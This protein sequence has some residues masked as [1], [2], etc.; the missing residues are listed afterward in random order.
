MP[1]LPLR[2]VR[3]VDKS[4][5]STPDAESKLEPFDSFPEATHYVSKLHIYKNL[6]RYL[7]STFAGRTVT[8]PSSRKAWTLFYACLLAM[9]NINL[10]ASLILAQEMRVRLLEISILLDLSSIPELL[11]SLRQDDTGLAM[12][13]VNVLSNTK[14]KVLSLKDQEASK[15]LNLMQ[16]ILDK[17]L[18]PD[19]QHSRKA[20]RFFVKLSETSDILPHTVSIEGVTLGN[21]HPVSRGGFADIYYGEYGNRAVA[22]KRLIIRRDQDSPKIQRVFRREALVWQQLRHP[23]ILPFLGVTVVDKFPSSMCMVSP[24]M[25]NGTIREL[26]RVNG[27]LNINIPRRI[28]EIG[29]G[30]AYLHSEGIIHGDLR[31]ANILV[32]DSWHA[33]LADFGLTVFNDATSAHTPSRHGSARWMAPELFVPEEFGMPFQRTKATDAYAFACVC[34]EI[35]AGHDPFF[36]VPVDPAVMLRV[37]QGLRPARPTSDPQG[38]S[39]DMPDSTWAL[40]QRCWTH[41]P[42]NRPTMIDVLADLPVDN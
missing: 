29:D 5:S 20:H 3:F 32:D 22:L 6:S 28:L 40:V 9:K 12:L 15:F 42:G 25:E 1:Y 14:D 37:I 10:V 36:E 13:L 21:P 34:F 16:Y 35:Y 4:T 33:C 17:D 26:R 31:G 7:W 41:E 38:D 18:L 2:T 23:N 27:A 8:S 11:R 24:W 30:L 39:I 19:E